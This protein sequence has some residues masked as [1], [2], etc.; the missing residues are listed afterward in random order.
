[1]RNTFAKFA[2]LTML[3]ASST[4]LQAED[5]K[6][7][8]E[9]SQGYRVDKL[10]WSVSGASG[11]PDVLS[12][13]TFKDIQIYQTRVKSKASWHGYFTKVELGYGDILDG[14]MKDREYLEDG[15]KFA[16]S[17]SRHHVTGSCTL[18][19]VVKVGKDFTVEKV[20]TVTPLAG[21]SLNM[22]KLRIRR[23]VQTLDA[24]FF[25]KI[26][27][28][29]HKI[30]HVHSRY[31]AQ[32]DAPFIGISAGRS[33]LQKFDFFAE[34]NFLFAMKYHGRGFWNF[35]DNHFKQESSRH[36]GFGHIGTL[37]AGYEIVPNLRT[38]VEYQFS[39][40]EAKGGEQTDHFSREFKTPF[41]KA[42][43]T[44]SEVRFGLECAF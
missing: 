38:K 3:V 40:L 12:D 36:K 8:I 19:A 9:A 27:R 1:M 18:D 10:Q 16:F 28:V 33:F 20:W 44:S 43:L 34:Y 2:C 31:R 29:H 6:F 41:R 11:H 17:R 30:D 15:R 7:D 23:G 21:Y 42:R 14:R 35:R 37:S 4:K 13:I 5:I 32:F 39:L 22:E 26:K 25:G 24:S